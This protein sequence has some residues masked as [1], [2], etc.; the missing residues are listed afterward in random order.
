MLC[1][2][3]STENSAG[4]PYCNT[5]GSPLA[6]AAGG[7]A[8]AYESAPVGAAGLKP[9]RWALAIVSGALFLYNLSFVITLGLLRLGSSSLSISLTSNL[10]VNAVL[11]GAGCLG[12]ALA[13]LD[14]KSS[15]TTIAGAVFMR[16][17][18]GLA[19]GSAAG[20]LQLALGLLILLGLSTLVLWW[21]WLSRPRERDDAARM[22]MA[23]TVLVSAE[24]LSALF[25]Y[26]SHPAQFQVRRMAILAIVI[27]S[28]LGLRAWI[29]S[30]IA[31]S[32]KRA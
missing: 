14:M 2:C 25:G 16:A 20:P 23:L 27:G 17:L 3:C 9:W 32:G 28:L 30:A 21:I 22:S 18:L 24:A 19:L 15:L 26:A 31:N 8:S 6:P 4:A 29:P 13:L 11:A 10:G 1:T 12:L 7:Q 5:C